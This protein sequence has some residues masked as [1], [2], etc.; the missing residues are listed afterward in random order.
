MTWW[1]KF[2]EFATSQA[3]AVKEEA[4]KARD[5]LDEALARKERELEATPSERVDMIL[6]EI[7]TEDDRLGEIE[8]RL[9]ARGSLEPAEA[10][11]GSPDD[12]RF[13]GVRAGLTVEPVEP[14]DPADR[15]T[16]RVTLDEAVIAAIGEAGLDEAIFD[17][18]VHVM[19]LEASRNAAIIMLRTPTLTD[20]E[21][22][23]L[24]AGIV[25]ANLP[26]EESPEPGPTAES[27]GGAGGPDA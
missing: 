26:T 17:L 11:T 2:L 10:D 25:A 15:T 7:E 8:E 5:A 13:A 16:H 1:D 19:V 20:D 9:R 6:D 12:S 23:D 21:V 14:G 18:Q 24:V 22:G 3:D 4:G 27:T